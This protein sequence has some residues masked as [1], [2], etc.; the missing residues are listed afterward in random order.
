MI[1]HTQIS[2]INQSK[3][4]RISSPN[5]WRKKTQSKM[6]WVQYWK[7]KQYKTV[8]KMKSNYNISII[9]IILIKFK[10]EKKKIESNRIKLKWNE[11]KITKI[12]FFVN[13]NENK[14]NGNVMVIWIWLSVA[15]FW[16]HFRCCRFWFDYHIKLPKKIIII[17]RNEK[18]VNKNRIKLTW[19]SQKNEREMKQTNINYL[20]KNNFLYGCW[21]F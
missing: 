17:N 20:N 19:L 3:K 21:K 2:W 18:S 16:I 8:E 9:I 13:Q 4:K 12:F 15:F 10:S 11:K 14:S 5:E 1:H 6:K 7:M